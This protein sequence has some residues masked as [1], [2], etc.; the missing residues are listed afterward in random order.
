MPK[1]TKKSQKFPNVSKALKGNKRALGTTNSGPP[2]RLFEGKKT[3]RLIFNLCLL[4]SND[5]EIARTLEISDTLFSRWK[6]D[7]PEVNDA[8]FEGRDA[9]D[10][11]IANSLYHRA[12]GYRH[13]D[14][15]LKV[16]SLGDNQGSVVKKIEVVKIYPPDT[17]AASLWLRNRKSKFWK[18]RDPETP[19]NSEPVIWNETKTYDKD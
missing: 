18:E 3:V 16:V 14:V 11:R 13:K 8:L 2:E 4:G 7:H 1:R 12:K 17:K 5:K 6:H 10:A 9:A 19:P 15:E